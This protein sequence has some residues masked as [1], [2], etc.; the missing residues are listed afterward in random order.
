VQELAAYPLE[1]PADGQLG[2]TELEVVPGE[3]EHFA[4][5]KAENQDDNVRGVEGIL[6][7]PG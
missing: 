6:I 2:S 7:L 1:L 3:A 5:A 4:L